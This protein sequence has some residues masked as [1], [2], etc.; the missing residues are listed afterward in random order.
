MIARMWHGAT[1]AA[2]ADD[3]LDYLNRTG[4]PD[5]QATEGNQGGLCSEANR[6]RSGSF[7][8]DLPLGVR[9]CDPQFRRSGHSARPVLS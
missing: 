6:G 1:D 2:K 9:R 7:C 4:V 5:L 3:Y 8:T